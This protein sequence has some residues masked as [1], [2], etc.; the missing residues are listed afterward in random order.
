[1]NDLQFVLSA[2]WDLFCMEFTIYGFTLS[3]KAIM[4]WAMVAGLVL[5]FIGRV[6]DND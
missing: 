6:F 5:Y 2:A 4:L 3:F 1:M